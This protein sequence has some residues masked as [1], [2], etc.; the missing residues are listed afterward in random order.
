MIHG[1]CGKANTKS[2]CMKNGK[3]SKY[4]PKNFHPSTSVD[5]D[6]YPRYKRRD[7]GLFIYKKGVKLDNRFVVPYNP[8]LLMRYQAH[9]NMEYCNKS[10]SIKYLF[11]YVNKGPDRATIEITSQGESQTQV[12]E[13]KQYYDCRYLAPCEAVWRTLG[14][15]IHHH[16]PPVQR[17][18]FHLPNEQCIY[19]REEGDIDSVLERN[20]GMQTM[21]L[22]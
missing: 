6:G 5:E 14:F 12:D 4:F 3:C 8:H 18:T 21:F 16:W 10:N 17:L 15:D 20:E 11:K 19:F 22:A 9:V 1:P 13:I 7:N 2:P